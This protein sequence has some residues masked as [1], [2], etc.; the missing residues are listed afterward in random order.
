MAED[1]NLEPPT[2]GEVLREEFMKPLGLT[3]ETV[4]Q[5]IMQE[6]FAEDFCELVARIDTILSGNG[7]IDLQDAVR[8]SVA[9]GTSI[10]FWLALQQ[11]YDAALARY[12][13]RK[14][15]ENRQRNQTLENL[16]ERITDDNQH[17]EQ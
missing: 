14:V 3:V 8:F 11:H 13:A 9:F 2:P 10:G 5:R 4:A 6:R 12:L 1:D 7:H 17:P 16:V 15:R